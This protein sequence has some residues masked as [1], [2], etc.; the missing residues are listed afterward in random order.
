MGGAT[1]LGRMGQAAEVANV[2]C[3]LLSDQASY[4]TGGK[5]S[6][7]S[8]CFNDRQSDLPLQL[9]GLLMVVTP[10][11]EDGFSDNLRRNKWHSKSSR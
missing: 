7:P 2:V 9:D 1:L 11:A 6:Y 10:H 5:N 3:F 4:V 8:V